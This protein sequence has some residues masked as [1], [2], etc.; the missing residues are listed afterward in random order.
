MSPMTSRTG[1][2]G[3]C[4]TT[5]VAV[6]GTVAEWIVLVMMIQAPTPPPTQSNPAY[7]YYRNLLGEGGGTRALVAD[8]AP[9]LRPERP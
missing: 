3:R 9:A 5:F 7:M 1:P 8:A 4:E 6:T 2:K